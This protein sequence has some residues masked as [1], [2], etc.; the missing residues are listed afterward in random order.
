MRSPMV[1]KFCAND[2]G[3]YTDLMVLHSHAGYYIGTMYRDPD[4]DCLV[5][6][7][8]DSTEYYS[9]PEAAQK[10]L[11]DKTFTQRAHA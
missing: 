8:R 4:L 6:G 10:A 2:A 3:R 11:S 1:A 5:P 9:T 7:S